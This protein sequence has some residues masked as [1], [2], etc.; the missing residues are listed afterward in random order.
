VV[1]FQDHTS[2]VKVKKPG[3]E[4]KPN[5]RSYAVTA[6]PHSFFANHRTY[7]PS[8]TTEKK[9]AWTVNIKCDFP[10]KPGH[11]LTAIYSSQL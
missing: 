5:F 11:K 4:P 2:P 6:M 9:R 3:S 7:H 1:K 8:E 10:G